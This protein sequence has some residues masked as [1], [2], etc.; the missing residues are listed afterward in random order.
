M[1]DYGL[2]GTLR[3]EKYEIYVYCEVQDCRHGAKL[4]LVALCKVLGD[5][6]RSVGDPNPLVAKLRCGTC[7]SKHMSLRLSPPTGPTGM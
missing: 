5:D 1:K 6:F 3:D 2:L 4:D 7:G